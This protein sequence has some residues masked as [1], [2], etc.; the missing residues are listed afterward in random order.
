MKI[1]QMDD[2]LVQFWNTNQKRSRRAFEMMLERYYHTSNTTPP[3]K[4]SNKRR[5]WISRIRHRTST[6]TAPPKAV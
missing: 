1:M 5:S 4:P 6:G 2:P 3:R